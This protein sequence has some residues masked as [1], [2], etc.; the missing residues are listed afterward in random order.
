MA[1]IARKHDLVA[2]KQQ[3]HQRSLICALFFAHCKNVS[4]LESCLVRNP[5]ERISFA[6]RPVLDWYT[7]NDIGINYKLHVLAC[8]INFIAYSTTN[9]L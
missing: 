3:R 5:K 7:G 8:T 2:C 4:K 1:L 9:S 6:T